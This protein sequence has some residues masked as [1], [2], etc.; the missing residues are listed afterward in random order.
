MA[1]Y[2]KCL[3]VMMMYEPN[4]NIFAEVELELQNS[5]KIGRDFRRDFEIIKKDFY[6]ELFSELDRILEKREK[7]DMLDFGEIVQNSLR[8]AVTNTFSQS[9]I[10]DHGNS[11]YMINADGTPNT[12]HTK[13]P[14]PV[15]YVSNRIMDKT[16]IDQG[17]LADVAPTLLKLMQIPIPSLMTGRVLINN[18]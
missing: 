4:P 16:T 12:A 6:K 5:V 1:W 15:I 14:V 2:N 17:I 13:N 9:I 3:L 10:A 7:I 11:D 8:Y 18:K